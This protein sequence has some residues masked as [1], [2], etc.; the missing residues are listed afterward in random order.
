M[1]V[2]I[3]SSL[4]EAQIAELGAELVH[5]RD[6][7]GRELLSDGNP[8]F[9]A[10]RSPLLFPIV[11][12][13]PDDRYELSGREYELK[14]HG[15]ARTSLF[16]LVDASE[17]TCRFRL[18]AN[19]ETLRLYPFTF[20]LDVAYRIQGA[21]LAIEVSACNTGD[22]A[23]PVSFGFHPALRW[24]LP[25]GGSREAHEI[26]FERDEPAPLRT[27]SDGLIGK[28]ERP[29]PVEGDRLRLH[30]DLFQDG[31]LIF[32]RHASR[33]VHYGVPGGRSITVGFPDM[34]HLGIWT[35]PGAGFVCIEPWQGYAS[36]VD[37]EGGFAE[38]PGMVSIPP[39]ETRGF[40]MQITVDPVR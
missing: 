16:E 39:G 13:L 4:L 6:E 24:P 36:P 38:K 17:A 31:A 23:M 9:W 1:T 26:R 3:S 35:K 20:K 18:S 11:G 15:F 34:P 40:G 21:T 29:S 27:L 12:K 8:A 7:A 33:K 19:E 5:L 30:D 37:F 28:G 10:G 14:Q 32:D 25:Y 22:T 2:T